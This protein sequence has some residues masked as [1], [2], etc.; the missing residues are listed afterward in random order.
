MFYIYNGIL[1][2]EKNE[3][4][5]FVMTWMDLESIMLREI[6]QTEK[7]K[8]Y[9]ISLICGLK[10]QNQTRCVELPGIC[11]RGGGLR[12]VGQIGRGDREVQTSSYKNK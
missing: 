11:Q 9:V 4:L 12:G 2:I 3:I 5:P 6:S 10:Q 1:V 8:Y 7:D